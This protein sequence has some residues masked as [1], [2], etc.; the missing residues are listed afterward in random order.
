MEKLSKKIMA[1][2]TPWK[3]FK[4]V[5]FTGMSCK[6]NESANFW[7]T[8]GV[9]HKN[10]DLS[11]TGFDDGI[12][13][14]SGK[15]PLFNPIGGNG[16]TDLAYCE[17]QYF[18]S[19]AAINE[20]G[21]RHG[22][23]KSNIRYFKLRNNQNVKAN[24]KVTYFTPRINTNY[25]GN[26]SGLTVMSNLASESD[27]PFTFTNPGSDWRNCSPVS[28][29][30]KIYSKTFSLMPGETKWIIHKMRGCPSYKSSNTFNHTDFNKRF[31]TFMHISAFGDLVHT[32]EN[33]TQS[34]TGPVNIQIECIQKLKGKVIHNSQ[35]SEWYDLTSITGNRPHVPPVIA[36]ARVVPIGSNTHTLIDKN[37]V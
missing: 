17:Y 21:G 5:S 25:G 37:Y 26:Y 3:L 15:Y 24:L 8:M 4:K 30:Y 33:P 7:S 11:T 2:Q 9:Y 36:T 35:K 20:A 13:E 6:I 16:Y 23:I 14:E 27:Q 18:A 22:Y 28:A 12:D 10:D 34:G 19:T 32:H 1:F 29:L 31:T